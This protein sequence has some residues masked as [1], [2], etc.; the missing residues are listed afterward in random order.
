MGLTS[1]T[2]IRQCLHDSKE[3][4]VTCEVGS[5]SNISRF[6]QL[7][8]VSSNVPVITHLIAMQLYLMGIRRQS[9]FTDHF[10]TL[11]KE[12]WRLPIVRVGPLPCWLRRTLMAFGRSLIKRTGK[13]LVQSLISGAPSRYTCTL[14]RCLTHL[15][16]V[17][18]PANR[19]WSIPGRKKSYDR[20]KCL[21]TDRIRDINS[22]A[23]VHHPSDSFL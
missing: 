2:W 12:L 6:A 7:W 18:F 10:Q 13:E 23:I 20:I 4:A 21:S 8:S 11:L 15:H 9:Q 5:R 17:R 14:R 3:G 1:H 19:I 22:D 16:H